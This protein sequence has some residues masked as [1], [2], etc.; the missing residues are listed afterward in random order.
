MQKSEGF[1]RQNFLIDLL[2]DFAFFGSYLVLGEAVFFDRFLPLLDFYHWGLG[3][4]RVYFFRCFYACGAL[5]A[6]VLAGRYFRQSTF[7]ASLINLFLCASRSRLIFATLANSFSFSCARL[8][9][10]F[11]LQN[12]ARTVTMRIAFVKIF[13]G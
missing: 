2:S 12:Q 3:Y 9:M 13:L 6:A 8:S 7:F 4:L 1:L 10:D 11:F 5:S